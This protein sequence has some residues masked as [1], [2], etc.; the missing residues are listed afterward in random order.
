MAAKKTKKKPITTAILLAAGCGKKIWPYGDT[1]PKATLPV[2]NRSVIDWQLQFLSEAGIESFVVV[3]G[4]LGGEV[5]AAVGGGEDI[6]FVDQGKPT[7][8]ADATLRGLAA[9]DAEN[10]LVV[11]GDTLWTPE[12]LGALLNRFAA[13]PAHPA[14]LAAPVG[15]T[16]PQDWLC[17]RV[18]DGKVTAVFGH[19]REGEYRHAGLLAIPRSF[20]NAVARVPEHMSALEV[21]VMPI[22]EREVLEAINLFTRE[23]GT[24]N[25][26]IAGGL[27]FDLDKPWQ[28][29]EANDLWLHDQARRLTK[30][31]IHSTATV[32][33]GLEREG[34]IVAGKNAVVGADVKVK[35][36][37]WIGADAKVI[38]G[39][40]LCGVASIGAGAK[41]HQ[42]CQVGSGTSIGKNCVVGH[43]A[44]FAGLL[45][46][47][48][49]SYHYGEYWGILGRH[50]DLGAAT[51]C[52]TLRFDDQETAH[53]IRGRRE[54]PQ[55]GA[56]ASYLGDY[57]RTGVNAILMPGVKVGSCS[58]IGAGVIL[59][60]DAPNGSLIHL[61]QELIK[62]SW[63]PERYG[64]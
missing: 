57:V 61:K 1:Q 16:S 42:Y 60:E 12:D 54:T 31:L 4:H 8:T 3:T 63:G 41:V 50:A 36:T 45:M 52:G 18:E 43:C 51:V 2:A 5:R 9:T 19:P 37:A 59:S 25:A 64:W 56:N 24:T 44:E 58:V 46:E 62:R 40:I 33:K 6:T 53:R 28:L 27:C 32:P 48:A 21:G 47:G 35:G 49:Y 29:L 17:P 55:Y 38:D 26:V 23:G 13:D 11:W 34:Y 20:G 30:D 7:G 39:A 15:L 10:V 22:A 14:L